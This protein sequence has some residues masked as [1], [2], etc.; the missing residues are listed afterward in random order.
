MLFATATHMPQKPSG[1]PRR[2]FG[3]HGVM[4]TT[5]MTPIRPKPAPWMKRPTMSSGTDSMG[6]TNAPIRLPTMPQASAMQTDL[7]TPI[8]RTNEAAGNAIN[9][10]RM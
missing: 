5:P 1:A 7:R 10:P 3:N 8:L 4:A 2:S 9:A 6:M